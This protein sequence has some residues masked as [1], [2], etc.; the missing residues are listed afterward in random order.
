MS[1]DVTTSTQAPTQEGE[2]TPGQPGAV[3]E[4]SVRPAAALLRVRR[5]PGPPVVAVRSWLRGGGRV[6]P[7][8]GVALITGRSLSE[9]TARS[10]WRELADRSEALGA[11]VGSAASFEAHGAT[12][13]V[14]S[15]HWREGLDWAVDLLLEPS[16]PEDRC[17][18]MAR[19]A[20]SELDSLRDQPEVVTGWAFL[21]Q[22]FT[23]HPRCRPIQGTAESLAAI[24]SEECRAF[25]DRARAHAGPTFIVA[26]D[27]DEA[28]AREYLGE[29]LAARGVDLGPADGEPT[30]P[31]GFPEPPAP[32]GLPE[33]HRTITLPPGDQAHLFAGCLTVRRDHPDRH[34]LELLGVILGAGAGL[35][36]RLPERVREREGLAYTV[37][38]QTLVGAG[39]DPGRLV[40]YIGTGPDTVEQAE[41][42]VREE[43][44]RLVEDGATAGEL[45]DARSYL[46]GRE[47]FRRETA[48][49]WADL[50]GEAVLYG[51]PADPAWRRE[52]LERVDGEELAAVARR[53]LAPARLAVTVGLP[54]GRRSDSD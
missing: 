11:A 50:M 22:L 31:G 27:L 13:D 6:E 49:Q 26:G 37:Y 1:D 3:F 16:F 14:R 33:R 5:V 24:G 52:R 53:H 32:E 38:V 21:E 20:A 25:H 48:R 7:A 35:S 4:P 10:D 47:P 29:L 23:P 9:G 30:V 8:P 15:V 12:V 54:A 40:V 17:R 46:L 36:G 39:L 51:L 44:G 34:A 2:Q 41:R 42:A 45:E 19:Q 28:A 18:W 43:L